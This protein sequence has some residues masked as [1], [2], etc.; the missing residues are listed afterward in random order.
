MNHV[1]VRGLLKQ[2][3]KELAEMI[4]EQQNLL[5]IVG[6]NLEARYLARLGG[7]E[8]ELLQQQ[9]ENRRQTRQVEL[10]RVALNQRKNP[11]KPDIE[12][13][14]DL[15]L[16]EWQRQIRDR[17]ER[18]QVSRRRLQKLLTP[19]SSAAVRSLYRQLVKRLHP[20]LHP[21][22]TQRDRD[23]WFSVQEAYQMS[24]WSRMETL[25]AVTDEEWDE[26]PEELQRMRGRCEELRDDLIKLRG[27]FPHNIANKLNDEEWLK[28]QG[29]Q[30]K[31][32][33][34]LERQRGLKLQ[35]V[36]QEYW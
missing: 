27:Q 3:R 28:V 11:S 13:Q 2:T 34:L 30:L 19:E 4:F 5:L 16:G 25:L 12:K 23:L 26:S 14:L 10:C 15:E 22:Q 9:M 8:I 17:N 7:L 6:P 24:N 31:L 18:V 32:R 1:D 20:D 33:I 35:A 36:A 21:Q 29:G